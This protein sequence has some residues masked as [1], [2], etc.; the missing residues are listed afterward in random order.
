MFIQFPFQDG[1]NRP[2]AGITKG[3]SS[4]T[5]LFKPF[6][7]VGIAQSQDTLA[8]TEIMKGV[9]FEETFYSLLGRRTD[10]AG[11]VATPLRS[12]LEESHFFRCDMSATPAGP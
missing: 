8:L 9:L 11:F 6:F 3:I 1:L 12:T 4:G 7:S 2:V 5:G 10:L